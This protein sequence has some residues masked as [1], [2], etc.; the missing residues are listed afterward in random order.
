MTWQSTNDKTHARTTWQ[1]G[2]TWQTRTRNKTQNPHRDTLKQHSRIIQYLARKLF[3]FS[4]F[5]F[6]CNNPLAFCSSNHKPSL[7]PLGYTFLKENAHNGPPAVCVQYRWFVGGR[8]YQR[9]QS[10]FHVNVKDD[11]G[12]FHRE[13]LYLNLNKFK[14]ICEALTISFNKADSLDQCD[15]KIKVKVC[16][17]SETCFIVP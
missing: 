9:E 2:I 16:I 4:R 8:V 11:Q 13:I 1:Q 6:G 5:N 14:Q 15:D 10:P 12:K 3:L 17:I 7:F